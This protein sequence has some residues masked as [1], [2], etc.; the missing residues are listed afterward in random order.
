MR[1]GG[2]NTFRGGNRM[3]VYSASRQSG[4]MTISYMRVKQLL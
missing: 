3:G 1:H 2:W 4:A